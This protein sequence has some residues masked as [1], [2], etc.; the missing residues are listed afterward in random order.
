MEV[1]LA[2]RPAAAA[3]HSSQEGAKLAEARARV[4]E[5]RRNS[6]MMYHTWSARLSR[7]KLP[8]TRMNRSARLL[9]S[10]SAPLSGRRF[11][12]RV[13]KESVHLLMRMFA[14]LSLR[15]SVLL[16][17]RLNV[18]WKMDRKSAGMSHV[19]NVGMSLENSAT[20]FLP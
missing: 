7:R 19:R 1:N 5:S 3:L 6:A 14:L 8:S 16:L 4:A 9:L 13:T 2:R 17:L 20:R 10:R 18:L 15:G 12:S 11:V